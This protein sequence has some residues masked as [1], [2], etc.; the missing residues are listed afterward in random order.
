MTCLDDR[1]LSRCDSSLGKF[2]I[3]S[4]IEQDIEK[5][6]DDV[7]ETSTETAEAAPDRP[8]TL[9]VK[10]PR[11]P[12]SMTVVGGSSETINDV[13]QSI[14][15]SPETCAFTC[16]NLHRATDDAVP[17]PG[18]TELG[19]IPDLKHEDNLVLIPCDYTEKDARTHFTRLR[20]LINGPTKYT[21]LTQ[22]G[23][24]GGLSV[25]AH[26]FIPATEEKGHAFTDPAPSEAALS[27]SLADHYPKGVPAPPPACVKS[28]ALSVWHPPPH[29]LRLRGDLMYISV[30]TL[31]GDLMHISATTK[32]FYIN[33]SSNT[34][35]DS[36]QRANGK[37]HKNHSLFHLLSSASPAF[38]E[39]F[40][41]LQK[42]MATTDVLSVLPITNCL[43]AFPWVVRTPTVEPDASRPQETLLS[44]GSDGQE[45]S[46]DWNDELQSTREMPRSQFQDRVL[47]ERLT[48][49]LQADLTDAAVRGAIAIRK[50]N[51]LSLNPLDP[52]QA[53]MY[54]YGNLFFSK[55]LDG[56]ETFKNVGGDEAAR[57]AAVK[58]LQ[59][60]RIF[61]SLDVKGLCLLGTVVVDYAGERF[62]AQSI[63]P[64]I[65]RRK[66]EEEVADANAAKK[67]NG[68]ED[69]TATE[70]EKPAASDPNQIVYG[71]IEPGEAIA[72]DATFHD[73][74]KEAAQFLHIAE[75]GVVDA[76]SNDVKTLYTSQE[77]KGLLGADGRRYL[78]DLYRLF[79]V[80][81][82]FLEDTGA[83]TA[84]DD[85]KERIATKE[86][87]QNGQSETTKFSENLYAADFAE[88]YP[89][90]M[91]LLR[92]ELIETYWEDQLRTYVRQRLAEKKAAKEKEAD[93]AGKLTDGKLE[94]AE[95]DKEHK[96][97][98]E[99]QEQE[100]IDTS[101]FKLSFNLD[102]FTDTELPKE[103]EQ[104]ESFNKA[105][106]DVRAASR[107][108]RIHVIPSFVVDCAAGYVTI[109]LDGVGLSRLLHQ[110]GINM[111]YLGAL[112]KL[113]DESAGKGRLPAL[114]RLVMQEL[115]VRGSKHVLRKM[116]QDIAVDEQLPARVAYFLSCLVGHGDA[117]VPTGITLDTVEKVHEAIRAEVR[118]RFR[119][120]LSAEYL[121]SNAGNVQLLREVAV[122][123]GVQLTMREYAF[124]SQSNGKVNGKTDGHVT[125]IVTASDVL[126]IVPVVKDGS[127]KSSLAEEAFEAG[128]VSLMQGQKQLGFELLFESLSLHEQIYG[129]LHPEVSRCYNALAMIYYQ[130][131]EKE[132]AVEL[133]RKALV[134]SERTIGID[135]G[136]TVLNYL[137]LSLFEHGM[138][139]T[140][141]AL[142]CLK[143]ALQL[144]NL[145][146]GKG[147]PD[148][149]TI[150]N[151]LS[152]MLQTLKDFAKA[153]DFT[154]LAKDACEDLWGAGNALTAGALHTL[155][156]SLAVNG[157]L[158]EA[159]KVERDAY[160]IFNEKFG[161][162]DQ[163]T[164]ES[165]QWLSQLTTNAVALAKLAK[166]QVAR[167]AKRLHAYKANVQTLQPPSAVATPVTDFGSRGHM[168]ID[169]L[170]QYIGE[171]GQTKAKQRKKRR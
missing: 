162:E 52:P 18:M 115:I 29:H 6:Q 16:F 108:L 4:S 131:E 71:A 112:A 95:K 170:V 157:E 9:T 137:N 64:G 147:H 57:I 50:G 36:A 56:V 86:S 121:S 21:P 126:N 51:V 144:W 150:F 153:L 158:K 119:Y 97:E 85:E 160:R 89:H 42:D 79:P 139:N 61:N 12:N 161:P 33:R 92:P 10:I 59:G 104:L 76:K 123:C 27:Y 82:E 109:P 45:A 135:S 87:G 13:K 80:D 143:R 32:G 101:D 69:A 54:I 94:A 156:Q 43:P 98:Q 136:E 130:S 102:A 8:F 113:L 145:V 38:N 105:Q 169:E 83:R 39:A 44:Y 24:D 15:E 70:T 128:R 35:F 152:V 34:H 122:R 22:L 116:L 141:I 127:A 20:D 114:Q 55:A 99:E 19:Q 167:E 165:E 28:L 124:G 91:V 37:A 84:T 138:G 163:R 140:T 78:L 1:I 66:E 106:D 5:K 151:N 68:T 47:R 3:M 90:Q 159:L 117:E 81:V 149:P 40:K 168:N 31:E 60:V 107:F 96:P 26:Y 17:L 133:Q 155:A 88:K 134:V 93:A 120:D 48:H 129:I 58:D 100:R 11:E 53:Q 154:R 7:V 72:A 65:F 146:F 103:G 118:Q 23:I 73:M 125:P 77:T 67:E 63:V 41:K 74:L 110:R 75:H 111:R 25:A 46:R 49:K 2:V 148:I 14:I 62:V 30:L 132:A 164:K 166:G 171:P 142:T